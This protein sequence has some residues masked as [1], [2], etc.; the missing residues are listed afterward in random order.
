MKMFGGPGKTWSKCHFGLPGPGRSV[1][2]FFQ[3]SPSDD[4][5]QALGDD[6]PQAP[7]G[8]QQAPSEFESAVAAQQAFES[9]VAP[10]QA[11]SEFELAV[12]AKLRPI[13]SIISSIFP[14]MKKQKVSLPAPIVEEKSENDDDSDDEYVTDTDSVG[15]MEDVQIETDGEFTRLKITYFWT[16]NNLHFESCAS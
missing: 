11:P 3:V 10:Q 15:T 13:S 16:E 14:S 6:L 12:A 5:P 8:V 9:A 7:G 4:L 1:R 2:S